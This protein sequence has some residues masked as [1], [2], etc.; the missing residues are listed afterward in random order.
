MSSVKNG[1]CPR[2]GARTSADVTGMARPC[3]DCRDVDPYYCS[4]WPSTAQLRK[5]RREQVGT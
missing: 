2:C 4:Q 5:Q 1:V 3:R